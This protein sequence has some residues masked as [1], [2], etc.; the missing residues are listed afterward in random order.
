MFG[1]ESTEGK[2]LQPS[3]ETHIDF[4]QHIPGDMKPGVYTLDKINFETAS[5]HT[6]DAKME[7][8]KAS[9]EVVPAQEL[10]PLV[11]WVS[12]VPQNVYRTLKDREEN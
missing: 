12:V 11:T 6:V 1:F 10:A 9:F 3:T 7:T 4:E 5:G 8:D 2:S